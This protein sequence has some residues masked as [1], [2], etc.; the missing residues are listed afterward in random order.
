VN[1]T[2]GFID[3]IIDLPTNRRINNKMW[4]RCDGCDDCRKACPVGAIHN[5]TEPYW[6][7]SGDCDNFIGFS[8]HET[9]PSIK[10]F[11]HENVYPEIDNQNIDN[12][13]SNSGT[14]AM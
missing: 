10:K 13:K 11:W 8:D 14:P 2:I 9:I 1:G 7:N 6:L 4:K 5:E 3:K 12:I